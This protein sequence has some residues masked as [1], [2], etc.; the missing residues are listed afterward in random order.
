MSINQGEIWMV[1]FEPSVGSEIQKQRPAIIV[2]SDTMSRFGLRTVVPIT[3]WKG[4]YKDFPW[5]IQIENSPSNGLNKLSSIECF[6]VKNF[7]Q[8]RFVKQIGSIDKKLLYEVH[9]TI[10]KTLD[11]KYKLL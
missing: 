2:S 7:A 5:I 11:P 1:S 10:A 8:E 6:Q 4:Y 9:R 3:Q